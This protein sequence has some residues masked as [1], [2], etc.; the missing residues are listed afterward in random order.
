MALSVAIGGCDPDNV[1][2][3]TQAVA[4]GA[5]APSELDAQAGPAGT[6]KGIDLQPT[7]EQIAD[8]RRR[9]IASLPVDDLGRIDIVDAG[10]DGKPWYVYMSVGGKAV[11]DVLDQLEEQAATPAEVFLAVAPRTLA[12]PG[13]LAS[14][15]NDRAA[16]G[17]AKLNSPRRLSY[18]VRVPVE[19]VDLDCWSGRD[20]DPLS[21]AS[22]ID[23]FH[24]WSLGYVDWPTHSEYSTTAEKPTYGWIPSKN[25]R[26]MSVCDAAH[27][28]GGW[29]SDPE[30]TFAGL[31]YF[32]PYT[33]VPTY[34]Y[35]AENLGEFESVRFKSSGG[36]FSTY[37]ILIDQSYPEPR[38][39]YVAFGNCDSCVH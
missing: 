17:E 36:P 3:A 14:D 4:P 20:V 26:A 12:V 10:L 27:N 15:H 25:R 37:F 18:T 33:I 6:V 2:D 21:F 23:E 1:T 19:R 31:G 7:L 29:A 28:T 5:K 38:R 11:H 9:V 24:D 22:W 32:F 30:V 8:A 35:V 16:R 13:V 34:F 39:A